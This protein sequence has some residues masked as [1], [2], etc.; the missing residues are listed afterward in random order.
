[1]RAIGR[2]GDIYCGVCCCHL[3][4]VPMCG[5]V[6]T[7]SLNVITNNRPTARIGDLVLGFCGHLGVICSGSPTVITNNRLTAGVGDCCIGCLI[8][9]EVTGS[10]NVFIQ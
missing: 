8:A 3:G 5:V 2:I 10:P 1:M 9:I 7:G 6:V 4:C